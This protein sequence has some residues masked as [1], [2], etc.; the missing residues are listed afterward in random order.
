[1]GKY[2]LLRDHL[3]FQHGHEFE[4]TFREIEHILGAA[5]PASAKRPQW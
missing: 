3:M 4:L 5:L 1:M 2:D